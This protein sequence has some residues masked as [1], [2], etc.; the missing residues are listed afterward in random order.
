MATTSKAFNSIKRD[1]KTANHDLKSQIPNS[2][3]FD[4]TQVLESDKEESK[5]KKPEKRVKTRNS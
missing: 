4:D 3:G 1:M 5:P 2:V